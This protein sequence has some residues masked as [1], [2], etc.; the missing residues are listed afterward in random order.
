MENLKNDTF[1]EIYVVNEK[2]MKEEVSVDKP[3]PKPMSC[4]KK[5]FCSG[6][7]ITNL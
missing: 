2:K 5:R 1:N 7:K 3:I 4:D 6:V